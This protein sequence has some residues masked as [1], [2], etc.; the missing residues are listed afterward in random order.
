MAC[1]GAG[2]KHMYARVDDFKPS[3]LQIEGDGGLPAYRTNVFVCGE[4]GRGKTHL[5]CAIAVGWVRDSRFVTTTDI[6]NRIR[7]SWQERA[8]ETEREVMDQ[9][10]NEQVLVLDDLGAER[11]D[12]R[13]QSLMCQIIR[14]RFDKGNATIITSNLAR[15]DM[16]GV[17]DVR[18]ISVLK[19]FVG[20]RVVGV[21]RR[22][23]SKGENL[24][25]QPKVQRVGGTFDCRGQNFASDSRVHRWLA[26]SEDGRR[27]LYADFIRSNARIGKTVCG[28]YFKTED[29]EILHADRCTIFGGQTP[30]D[31]GGD[32]CNAVAYIE[33]WHYKRGIERERAVMRKQE[34]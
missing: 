5:A 12:E 13:V 27:A 6:C 16:D 8:R 4:V 17:I 32:E 10:I 20:I 1:F 31:I 26:R 3:D 22:R 11:G 2:R 24:E 14:A 30:D 33:E 34:A 7:Q 21:D 19:S 15:K 9:V 28:H 23:A 29:E 25:D 18:I